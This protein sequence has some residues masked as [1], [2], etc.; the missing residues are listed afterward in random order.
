LS[1]KGT[2]DLI[3]HGDGEELK[4]TTSRVQMKLSKQEEDMMTA[5]KSKMR[6]AGET[7]HR[8][9]PA[10][11]EI[12]LLKGKRKHPDIKEREESDGEDYNTIEMRVGGKSKYQKTDRDIVAAENPEPEVQFSPPKAQPAAEDA[13]MKEEKPVRKAMVPASMRLRQRGLDTKQLI[14]EDR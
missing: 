10:S 7:Y 13:V 2:L 11:V 12:N 14:T 5:V 9:A 4:T 3:D 6:Y 8:T 1:L